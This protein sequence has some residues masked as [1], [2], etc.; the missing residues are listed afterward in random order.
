V[1]RRVGLGLPRV[2]LEH[3]FSIYGMPRGMPKRVLAPRDLEH[4]KSAVLTSRV[5]P[6]RGP[7][8]SDP[9]R[10]TAVRAHTINLRLAAVRPVA[11]EAADA[12]LLRVASSSGP[13]PR[14]LVS[15]SW[16]RTTCGAR[17]PGSA[18]WQAANSSRSSHRRHRPSLS[19]L[20][21]GELNSAKDPLGHDRNLNDDHESKRRHPDDQH[22]VVR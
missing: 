7:P 13:R 8:L 9:P 14:T 1:L 19:S 10:A 22:K 16:P 21:R 2:P 11:Y 15:K 5:Q 3:L 6:H 18:I 4:A 12:G 17:V 20:L